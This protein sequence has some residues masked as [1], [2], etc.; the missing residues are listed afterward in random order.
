MANWVNV[1]ALF[2]TVYLL[3]SFAV[4][5]VRLTHRHYLSVC[6]AIGVLSMEVC[7]RVLYPL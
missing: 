4:L 6:L 5:P 3:L 1:A 7:R 2:L